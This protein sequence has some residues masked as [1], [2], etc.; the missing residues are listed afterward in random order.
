MS[1]RSGSVAKDDDDDSNDDNDSNDDD[2]SDGDN[3]MIGLMTY[4]RPPPRF[5]E[6]CNSPNLFYSV[7]SAA[8]SAFSR[9]VKMQQA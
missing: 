1:F 6:L 9:A 4:E 2:D 7:W 8:G 5:P 3:F